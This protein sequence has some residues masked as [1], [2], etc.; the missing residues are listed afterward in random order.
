MCG[1]AG[2]LTTGR[3]VPAA[4][5]DACAS[6]A[7][8]GPDGDGVHTFDTGSI[9]CGLAHRRLSIL[10]LSPAG[11]QPMA[12]EGETAWVVF[13]GE[14]YD[15]LELREELAKHG[16]RFRTRTDTEVLLA[17]WKQWGEGMLDRLNGM[18]AFAIWDVPSRSLFLARDRFGEKPLFW[19]QDGESFVF[20]SELRA[21][22]SFERHGQVSG[23][24]VDEA[25]LYRFLQFGRL[26]S[27]EGS[28]ADGIRR[29]PAG[30]R[31][32]V[33]AGESGPPRV[34]LRRW[35]DLSER[36][37]GAETPRDPAARFREVFDDSVRLRLRA[38]VPV[39]TSLSGGI[40]SGSMVT[41]LSAVL[42]T[43]GEQHTFTCRME[44]RRLDEG[45][46]AEETARAAHA[47]IH[48][49][50]PTAAELARDFDRLVEAQAEPFQSA[51]LYAQWRVFELAKRDGVT[52][53]LDGQG[54]DEIL[55]GYSIFT[56][57]AA[58]QRLARFRWR[59]ARE[60]L[61]SGPSNL[62]SATRSEARQYALRGLLGRSVLRALERLRMP[63]GAH[64]AAIVSTDAR[65]R[66]TRPERLVPDLDGESWLRDR[67]LHATTEG[68]LQMLLRFA[69]RNSMA[70][71]REVRLPFLDHR[72][73]ELCFALP[74]EWKIGGGW[75][76][77]VLREAM[78]GRVPDAVRRRR[79]KIGFEAP[80]VLWL[81]GPL[82]DWFLE[83]VDAAIRRFP[84]LLDPTRA[85]ALLDEVAPDRPARA[86]A[87]RVLF[88]W[89]SAEACVR[90]AESGS[91]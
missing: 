52:V 44:D 84:S 15:Y 89:V 21:M 45:T 78:A 13:N 47:R 73:V 69:D 40:D 32:R 76:K 2:V 18:F 35:Y 41:T 62:A 34:E 4:L 30:H 80:D 42:G 58:G 33:T 82:R 9:R 59:E 72:L 61:A 71:S 66:F 63:R 83:R 3:I 5:S 31:M 54:A 49:V 28:I 81:T 70:H 1:I 8:R 29:L 20:A 86:H 11:A 16:H 85:R 51:S 27:D 43:G 6:L 24:A 77:R 38:D 25:W 64:S 36:A 90:L 23:T 87:V 7:H 67:L 48:E 22:R 50:T 10:D 26:E 37:R 65:R 39:G 91:S 57:V 74:D 88:P 79:D 17:A 56:A 46:F 53:L 12:A 14:I 75:T 68:P 60:V 55:A 19:R